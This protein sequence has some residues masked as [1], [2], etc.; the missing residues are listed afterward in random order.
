MI[1]HD[2]RVAA[3]ADRV[4]TMRQG[5][6]A[7]EAAA[8]RPITMREG[9][10]ATRCV[11][12]RA[13]R[14][15]ACPSG[16]SNAALPPPSQCARRDLSAG[17]SPGMPQFPSWPRPTGRM[18][19][20]VKPPRAKA[21]GAPCLTPAHRAQEAAIAP[22][23]ISPPRAT[24]NRMSLPFSKTTLPRKAARHQGRKSRPDERRMRD[25]AATP[26]VGSVRVPRLAGST[27]EGPMPKRLVLC[28]DGTRNTPDQTSPTNVTKVALSAGRPRR[29]RRGP[30]ALLPPR[31]RRPEMGAH[32]GA[33][34]SG[35]ACH[36]TWSIPTGSSRTTTSRATSWSTPVVTPMVYAGTPERTLQHRA[37]GE[38]HFE[39]MPDRL[40]AAED[41]FA[42]ASEMPDPGRFPGTRWDRDELPRRQD[43]RYGR[44]TRG[45]S[46]SRT[47][48]PYS[49]KFRGSS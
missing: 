29:G 9:R 33:A 10:V 14:W 16:M 35:S 48:Y 28:C 8:H 45:V 38:H 46:G 7:T 40:S 39:F 41:S 15:T 18:I 6:V 12:N 2:P 32:R 23:S 47:R 31:C 4:I 49:P 21:I 17:S 1:T 36:A 11:I 25:H 3:A 22:S 34:H 20:S 24:T 43:S 19:A 30:T 42:M 26:G 44:L 37:A 13:R 27:P 5:R